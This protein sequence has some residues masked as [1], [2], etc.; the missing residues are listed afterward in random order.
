[1]YTERHV[2]RTHTHTRYGDYKNNIFIQG[3]NQTKQKLC[4]NNGNFPLELTQRVSL[5]VENVIK[6][7]N[8][9]FLGTY[10]LTYSMVQSPS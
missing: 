4:V 1:M 8:R 2:R 3:N 10:L 6:M 7:I 5:D 9:A